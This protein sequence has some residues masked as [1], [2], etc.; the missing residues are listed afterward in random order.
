MKR[1]IQ[2][3]RHLLTAQNI[4]ALLVLNR[5]N[6]TYLTGFTGTRGYLLVTLDDSTL[7]TDFRYTEQA[8]SEMDESTVVRELGLDWLDILAAAIKEK[9][10]ETLG[11][12]KEHLTYAMYQSLAEKLTPVKLVPLDNPVGSLRVIKDEREIALIREAVALADRAFSYILSVIR[13]GI[14]END[15]A[16]ELEYFMRREGASGKS[17]DFIVASG[18]RGAMPH[19]VASDKIVETGD[20]ITMDFGCIFQGYCSDMTRTV[21]LGKPS[22]D[23]EELYSLVAEAL[24]VGTAYLKPGVIAQ[25]VDREVRNYLAA[26][27]KLQ[28]FGHGLGHGLGLEVHEPPRLAPGSGEELL[29]GMVVTVEPGLYIK[30]FGGVRIEDVVVCHEHD[31]EILTQSGRELITL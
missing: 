21:C 10:V 28:Y 23:Q 6:Y 18:T 2:R 17:F 3:L 20:L 1:R 4:D 13:P 24:K 29:R 27:N 30:G 7:F 25:E 26:K 5:I 19:G 12:E 8:A 31:I 16:L 9:G 22:A 11:F 14:R 15:I